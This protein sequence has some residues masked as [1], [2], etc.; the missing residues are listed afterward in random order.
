[1]PNINNANEKEI[2]KLFSIGAKFGFNFK[3][4]RTE[5]MLSITVFR[6]IVKL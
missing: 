5:V 2:A 4:M 3:V 6:I 1:M